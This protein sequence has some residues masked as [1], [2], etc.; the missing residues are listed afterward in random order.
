MS[1]WFEAL[2]KDIGRGMFSHGSP[3]IFHSAWNCAVRYLFFESLQSSS[4]CRYFL[5]MG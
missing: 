5:G 4:E 3:L 2:K 1:G